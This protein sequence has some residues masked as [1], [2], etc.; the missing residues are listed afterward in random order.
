MPQES[1]SSPSLRQTTMKPP[2]G[3]IAMDGVHWVPVVYVLTRKSAPTGCPEVLK[4][5]AQ[6][7]SLESSAP[8]HATTKLPSWVAPTE[9]SYWCVTVAEL[10]TNSPPIALPYA[11]NRRAC[12]SE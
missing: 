9:G 10:T 1:P 11:S 4:R 6:I 8:V 7:P 3:S 12:T 5:R 2:D